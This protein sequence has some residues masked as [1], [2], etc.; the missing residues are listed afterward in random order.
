MYNPFRGQWT[1]LRLKLPLGTITYHQLEVVDKNLYMIGGYI[2]H[3]G[4]ER[5]LDSLYRLDTTKK[6]KSWYKMALMSVPRCYVS[7]VTLHGKIFA[8]GG[9]TSSD[10]GRLSSGEMYD[11]VLNLWSNVSEMTVERSDFAAVVF[12]DRI[13][14][15]GGFDGINYLNS[16]E[17]YNP[18]TDT[19]N[20]VGHLVTP[21]QGVTA[22]V[23][24]NKIYVLGGF[25]GVERLQSV[26]CFEVKWN[27]SLQWHHVPNM[28]T[29]R[30]NFAACRMENQD[31]MVIGGFKEDTSVNLR[32]VC[33]D[34]EILDITENVWRP[35][36]SL[37][38]AK[39]ALACISVNNQDLEFK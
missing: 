7:T 17:R 10:P 6:D 37:N 27:G 19:W 26:E 8:I 22:M 24:R 30:S 28:I 29:C 20:I 16:I 13:Y 9:R 5:F 36:P 34:V 1:P 21:R 38:K 2:K 32:A 39:S 11:P 12:E 23:C 3:Q 15:I 18:K 14:A 25:D 31:I 33:K 35:G 4:Q